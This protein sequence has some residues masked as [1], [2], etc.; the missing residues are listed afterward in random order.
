MIE[1][2]E[3]NYCCVYR[4]FKLYR[5][6]CILLNFNSEKKEIDYSVSSSITMKTRLFSAEPRA[7]YYQISV[8]VVVLLYDT[9]LRKMTKNSKQTFI[10]WNFPFACLI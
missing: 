6:K 1:S 9:F 2:P 5:A 7:V 4:S 8:G 10:I 3:I